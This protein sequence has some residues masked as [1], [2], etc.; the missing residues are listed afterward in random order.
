M[1]GTTHVAVLSKDAEG[2]FGVDFAESPSGPVAQSVSDS[3]RA[4]GVSTGDRLCGLVA[5]GMEYDVDS[6]LKPRAL[7]SIC[8]RVSSVTMTFAQNDGELTLE[9]TPSGHD[10][11]PIHMLRGLLSEADIS[12]I[13][14]AAI[15][16]QKEQH[17]HQYDN[18][19][20]VCLT[21]THTRWLAPNLSLCVCVCVCFQ[22]QS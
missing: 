16:L 3:A 20:K 2:S 11:T 22:G 13:H 10:E 9:A 1:P 14:A 6:R 19:L 12:D 7:A 5:N 4:A 17:I 15:E 21:H 8:A 18:E